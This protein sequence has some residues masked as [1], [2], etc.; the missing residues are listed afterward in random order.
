MTRLSICKR[1]QCLRASPHPQPPGIQGAR[2]ITPG[3]DLFVAGPCWRSKEMTPLW[4]RCDARCKE[5]DLS[6][7]W[8]VM[9]APC[10]SSKEMAPSHPCCNARCKE[11]DLSLVW[12]VASAPC[13]RSKEVT[14][15]Y[16][17][18]NARCKGVDLS[19]VWTIMSAP[20][21][22]SRSKQATFSYTSSDASGQATT[23]RTMAEKGGGK[24]GVVGGWTGVVL[25]VVCQESSE[26][27]LSRRVCKLCMHLWCITTSHW[28]RWIHGQ[29]CIALPGIQ[30]GRDSLVQTS[31]ICFPQRFMTHILLIPAGSCILHSRAKLTTSTHQQA[32]N[33]S[34]WASVRNYATLKA[35]WVWQWARSHQVW[36]N[37]SLPKK[38]L[39]KQRLTWVRAWAWA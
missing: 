31:L 22:G 8:A 28:W 26:L 38:Q 20:C 36:K 16:P 37:G 3:W 21:S 25:I 29:K 6:L 19:L 13:R 7:V 15:S 5:V 35:H 30:D 12:A 4:P 17:Y 9:S 24:T 23:K 32:Y 33:K 11:V 10:W 1:S 18:C 34:P 39:P 14:L 2:K 27:A